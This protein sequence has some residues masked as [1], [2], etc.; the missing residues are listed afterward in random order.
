M[1]ELTVVI[2]AAGQGTRMRSRLPK[3]LHHL[4]NRPLL[5]HVLDTA[6]RL[7]PR[8]LAVVYGHGGEQVRRAFAGR[9]GITWVHQAEQLG[10]GHAVAQALEALDPRGTVLVLYGDVPLIQEATLRELLAARA[11]A[12]LVLLTAR[13]ADPT[14]YGRIV[15]DDH[16]RLQAIVEEKDASEAER[17]I[18][19]VNTG[20]LAAGAASLSRWV[21]ALER[22]NAQGEYYL[23]DVVAMAVAEGVV[24][25]T[26]HPR[27]PDEFLGVNDRMQLAQL[28]RRY[29][30]RQAE[31][32][33]R[34][35]V[36]LRD[37]AR[38]DVRGRVE[39]GRDVAIDVDVILEGEVV[40]GE[41]VEIGPFCHLKDVRLGPGCKVLSHSVLE[42]VE[43]A[44]GVTIG[45]FARLR[46]GTSLASGAKVGNFVEIKNAQ[47]GEGS[48]I[49]HLSYVGDAE[50][51][52]D[53]NI[54]AGTITCNYDG[55][56][57]HRTIIGDHAFIG[58]DSQL[59]APVRIGEGATIGAGSTITRDA[60][61]HALTLSRVPQRTREGWQRPVKPK[62]GGS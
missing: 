19:E 14:G 33:M 20:V 47:V 43:A 54:G 10:T 9:S 45:P 30:H 1:E 57:K 49:N 41:G 51:G 2:L 8:E 29:Q 16:G 34:A 12:E 56:N 28:E 24:V 23:T 42:S 37:P 44:E 46:P 38:L 5:A 48:K 4:G 58:S 62:K 53:V 35:G 39:V 22:G 40:L 17:L 50:V 52:R 6:E 15:R 32:L 61:P 7:R 13:L 25:A 59:V 11:E 55:A 36:S 26:C 60:P 31:T 3:V 21:A 27:E 18:D